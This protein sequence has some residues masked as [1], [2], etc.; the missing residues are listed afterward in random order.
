MKNRWKKTKVA[1]NILQASKTSILFGVAVAAAT[2]LLGNSAIAQPQVQVTTI[3]V[4]LGAVPT[5][6]KI[7][8]I[9]GGNR[10]VAEF[11]VSKDVKNKVAITNPYVKSVSSQYSDGKL[12]MLIETRFPVKFG[13]SNNGELGV[14]TLEKSATFEDVNQVAEYGSAIKVVEKKTVPTVDYTKENNSV[15]NA[16]VVSSTVTTNNANTVEKNNAGFV[17]SVSKVQTNTFAQ[18]AELKGINIKAEGRNAKLTLDLDGIKEPVISKS[19]NFL[20]I[21]LP[22]VEIAPEFQKNIATSH[23]GTPVKTLDVTTQRGNGRIILAGQTEEWTYSSYQT[24]KK[25]VIE[26]KPVDLEIKEQVY[27]GKPL[28]LNFQNMDVRA[29]LQVLA[30]FTGMNIVAS[31]SVSG[32]MTVRLKDVPWDQALDLV[33]EARNLQK[34]QNGNVVWVATRQE[35]TEKNKAQI[36]LKEQNNTL[37]PLMLRFFQLNHYKAEE[38]KKILEQKDSSEGSDGKQSG[39]FLSSRGSVGIDVRNNTVFIQDTNANLEEISRIIKRL[40]QASKQVLIEAKLVVV[41]DKFGREL[42]SKFGMSLNKQNRSTGIG[43]ANTMT[44]SQGAAGGG[45]NAGAASVVDNGAAWSNGVTGGGSI[46]FTILNAAMGNMLSF[47]LSALEENNRGKV[48]SNPRL[49]TTNNK[50]AEIKQGTEIPY[51]T[52]GSGNSPPTVQFKTAALKLGVTPQVSANGRVTMDLDISK[53]TI[54][55]LVNVQ[56]GGQVPSIDTR[57]MTTQ[58]TVNDGQTVVLGGIYEVTN[59]EDLSKVPLLGDIPWV[60]NLF[61][62]KSTSVDKVELLIFITPKVVEE[63]DLD[64]LTANESQSSNEIDLRKK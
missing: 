11:E 41:D 22:Q 45:T 8:H 14:I 27:K 59:R 48:I 19:G 29:I 24:D 25:T 28:T 44:G 35:I 49:L 60:G 2:P 1:S 16:P 10:L 63:S 53:D 30:D 21:D 34:Q 58:V 46:G 23:L 50:K 42:G 6:A 47:E 4:E 33:L 36:E 20:I 31:D 51:V 5:G 43:I 32:S 62:H 38:M 56:G 26:I 54:G 18:K 9:P 17:S 39:K 57:Q 61:K 13:I 37:A 12:R 15:N 64:N 40:D 3:K 7:M 52:P 55:Q